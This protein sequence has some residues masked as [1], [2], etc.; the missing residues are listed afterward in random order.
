MKSANKI[1]DVRSSIINTTLNV[2]KLYSPNQSHM[3][4]DDLKEKIK[5]SNTYHL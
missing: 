4:S 5:T 3:Y 2:N 1:L